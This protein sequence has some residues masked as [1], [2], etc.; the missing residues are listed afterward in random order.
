MSLSSNSVSLGTLTSANTVSGSNTISIIANALN[1]FT[2]S[3]N[4]PTLTNGANTI[5]VYSSGSSSAGTAGFGINLKANA[6]PSVGS[7]PVSNYGTCG[8]N[9]SY[10][11]ADVYNFVAST[12]T[13]ISNVSA[14]ADC[15]YTV[16]YVANAAPT[17]EAG[18]YSTT[19]TYIVTGTF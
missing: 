4:G 9:S 19:I 6:T 17:T 10:N 12:D 8:V 13:T 11:T 7:D 3:Y 2:L 16:S 1:G 5:P 14:E 15:V 18:A